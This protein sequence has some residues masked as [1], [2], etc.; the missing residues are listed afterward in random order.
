MTEHILILIKKKVHSSHFMYELGFK[1]FFET[2][3]WSP[4]ILFIIGIE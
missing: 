4:F 3:N 2:H 1:C